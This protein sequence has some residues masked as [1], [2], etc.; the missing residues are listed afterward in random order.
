[1]KLR[2]G[3][4]F[5]STGEAENLLNI[6]KCAIKSSAECLAQNEMKSQAINWAVVKLVE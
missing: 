1:M 4:S 2:Q 6:S 3:R 5:S